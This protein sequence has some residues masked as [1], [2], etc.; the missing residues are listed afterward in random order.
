MEPRKAE[1]KTK[2]AQINEARKLR[3]QIVKLEERIAPLCHFNPHGK[4]VGGY[5][6][7][8]G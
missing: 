8:G 3:P 6:C 5:N 2:S 4:D 7:G 1:L